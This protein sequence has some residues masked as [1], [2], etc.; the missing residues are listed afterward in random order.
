MEFA[1][2]GFRMNE[3]CKL[4]WLVPVKYSFPKAISELR[5]LMSLAMWGRIEAA[6]LLVVWGFWALAG[7]YAPGLE[8][9]WG[10]MVLTAL[11]LGPG[12]LIS[13]LVIAVVPQLACIDK[14][15]IVIQ[16]GSNCQR[17]DYDSISN[18]WLIHEL[19][20]DVEWRAVTREKAF[21][22]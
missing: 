17:Y 21:L 1:D 13:S 18:V 12:I 4:S 19:E 16:I 20:S 14:K 2:N 8:V 10:R 3:S 15:Y 22:R 6:S 9:N 11:L 7:H 5:K